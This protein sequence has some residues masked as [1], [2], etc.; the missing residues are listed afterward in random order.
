[1]WAILRNSVAKSV[2][3]Q[4]SH[5]IGWDVRGVRKKS[6]CRVLNCRCAIVDVQKPGGRY[7]CVDTEAFER[8]QSLGFADWHPCLTGE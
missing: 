7:H 2:T 3:G 4:L 1:M 8:F 5:W 6:Q